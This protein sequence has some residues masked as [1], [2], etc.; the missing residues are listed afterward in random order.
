GVNDRTDA[1]G[2]DEVVIRGM[3]ANYSLVLVNGRRVSTS[4][5]LWRGGDFDYHSIPMSAIE[6]VEV[7]R[8][9]MS[10]LYGSDA[11]GGVVNIITKRPTDTWSGEIN[12]DYRVVEPGRGG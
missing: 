9:P 2:R 8:G 6:R 12:G 10:S 11:I 4:D 5:A 3:G 7:V 1:T